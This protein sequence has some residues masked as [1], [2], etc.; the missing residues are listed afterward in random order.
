M[1]CG[2]RIDFE[3]M[4]VLFLALVIVTLMAP[5]GILLT[6][7]HIMHKKIESTRNAMDWLRMTVGKEYCVCVSEL[8]SKRV[9]A[10]TWSLR[11]KRILKRKISNWRTR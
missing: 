4:T 7:V 6:I 11:E 2:G 5:V 10:S 3:L 1:L 8:R 9:P